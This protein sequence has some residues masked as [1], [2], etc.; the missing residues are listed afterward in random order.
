MSPAQR[1]MLRLR[2]TVQMKTEDSNENLSA[3]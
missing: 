3:C 1:K 2:L